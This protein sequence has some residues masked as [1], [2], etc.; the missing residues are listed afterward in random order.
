MF[1]MSLLRTSSVISFPGGQPVEAIHQMQA[2]LNPSASPSGCSLGGDGQGCSDGPTLILLPDP[3]PSAS[4][5]N[6]RRPRRTGV[7]PDSRGKAEEAPIPSARLCLVGRS[8]SA[9]LA[10]CSLDRGELCAKVFSQR[11]KAFCKEKGSSGGCCR[12][13]KPTTSTTASYPT[14]LLKH[15]GQQM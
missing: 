11:V 13:G 8:S 14:S 4:Q 2:A 9:T 15:Y 5:L 1:I 3:P 6:S 7:N 12:L 10:S